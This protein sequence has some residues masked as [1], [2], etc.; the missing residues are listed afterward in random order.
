MHQV[1]SGA[2]SSLDPEW[3]LNQALEDVRTPRSERKE[4]V[5][6]ESCRARGKDEEGLFSYKYVVF[7]CHLGRKC[8]NLLMV[9]FRMASEKGAG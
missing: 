1:I 3:D 5:G 4:G 2:S 6:E 9:R 7:K 8:S